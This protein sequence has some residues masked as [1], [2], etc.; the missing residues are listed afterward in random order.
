MMKKP[1]MRSP[2]VVSATLFAILTWHHG[3]AQA[4]PPE[5]WTTDIIYG[6]ANDCGS[7]GLN[8]SG[9]TN[10]QASFNEN[11][12]RAPKM[13]SFGDVV[14]EGRPSNTS[15]DYEIYFRAGDTGI[16]EQITDNSTLR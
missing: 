5:L 16:T 13:N 9:Y 3:S 2:L 15:E 6:V 14:W 12:D 1:Q 7:A 8:C 11:H 10:A 4:A